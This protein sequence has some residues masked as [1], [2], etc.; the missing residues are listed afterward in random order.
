MRGWYTVATAVGRVVSQT[1]AL[2]FG[3][4][5]AVRGRFVGGHHVAFR[6]DHFRRQEMHMATLEAVR[7]AAVQSRLQLQ[8]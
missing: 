1:H 7:D 6:V 2:H 8:R 3:V 4:F 5:R